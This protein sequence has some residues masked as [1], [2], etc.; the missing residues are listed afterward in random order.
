MLYS[1]FKC[2]LT[3]PLVYL[4]IFGC[5]KKELPQKND[6]KVVSKPNSKPS[7]IPLPDSNT[8]FPLNEGSYWVYES[9]QNGEKVEG[10]REIDS[11]IFSSLTDSGYFATIQEKSSDGEILKILYK[12]DA[13]GNVFTRRGNSTTFELFCSLRHC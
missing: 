2:L 7:A 9:V 4:F 13:D 12:V 3:F 6:Q 8:F 11:V 5:Q 10:S 1:K